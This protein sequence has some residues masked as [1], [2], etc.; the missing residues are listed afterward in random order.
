[1]ICPV[2]LKEMQSDLS[3]L[4]SHVTQLHA[5][6]AAIKAAKHLACMASES[7]QL[8]QPDCAATALHKGRSLS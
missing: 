8:K 3:A 1:M 4:A 2:W 7:L 5:P 6:V